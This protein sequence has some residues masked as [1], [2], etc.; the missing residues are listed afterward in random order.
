MT[1]LGAVRAFAVPVLAVTLDTI[2]FSPIGNDDN[3][4][5]IA[6][7]LHP[8]IWLVLIAAL[9]MVPA[10]MLRQS[11]PVAVSL[12]LACYTI[13]LTC[14]IGL[15]PLIALLVGLYGAAAA[16]S[17]E[18]SLVCLTV[19][20]VASGFI[21]AYETRPDGRLGTTLAVAAVFL[22]FNLATWFFGLRS[23]RAR[24]REDQL[25][26]ERDRLTRDA[27]TA[28]RL[29]IARELH[30]ILANAITIIELQAA[31][32]RPVVQEDPAVAERSLRTIEQVADQA[33]AELRRLL[34]VLRAVADSDDPVSTEIPSLSS[35]GALQ[36]QADQANVEA[37]FV[38]PPHLGDLD[39][40]VELAAY[41]IVQEGLT[42]ATR[43][44]GQGCRVLVEARADRDSLVIIVSDDGKGHVSPAVA[45]LSTGLGLVGLRERVTLLGGQLD[46][47]PLPAGGWRLQ[48]VLPLDSSSRGTRD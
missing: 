32:A 23:A 13:L 41:R 22:L 31:G 27:V 6:F 35:L 34:V 45:D 9:P 3:L 16:A 14:S 20:L 2:L 25:I 48:A 17:F 12:G 24:M 26:V 10:L 33:M 46:A 29:T 39:P 38:I 19:S 1:A 44:A 30:D 5:S 11:H 7:L 8:P 37:L 36:H 28:E 42:N 18:H 47:G 40:S 15:R 21:V 4:D 43:H